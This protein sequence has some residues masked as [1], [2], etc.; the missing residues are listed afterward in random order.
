[1]FPPVRL[2]P[3]QRIGLFVALALAAL[4]VFLHF[5]FGGYFYQRPVVTRHA[6]VACPPPLA[7]GVDEVKAMSREQ[8]SKRYEQFQLC[9]DEVESQMLFPWQWVSNSP[10]IPWFGSLGNTLAALGLVTTLWGLSSWIFRSSM[11]NS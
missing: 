7:G 11:K 3:S 9:T 5:P 10:L 8:L 1:M 2:N 4:I 6:S